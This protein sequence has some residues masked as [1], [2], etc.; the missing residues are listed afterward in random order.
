MKTTILLLALVGS[1]AAQDKTLNCNSNRS[2]SNDRASFCEMR[3]STVPA[4][5]RLDVDPGTNGGI[6]IKGWDRAE[7]LVRQQVQTWEDSDGAAKA[8]AGQ[9]RVNTSAG[10]IRVDGPSTGGRHQGWS[11]SFEV[12]VPRQTDLILKAHNGGIGIS[13]VRGNIQFDAQNGGVHLTNLAGSV[14]GHTQNGG[15]HVELAGTRWDGEKLDVTTTNGGV[16]VTM[17][18]GY[19][20]HLETGTV[21]GGIHIDFPITVHGQISKQFST[22][23]NGGG[24]LVRVMTTNGGVHIG[25]S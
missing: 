25:K 21:N 19:A 9:V 23:I 13:G 14:H 10:Q 20:A 16:H 4:T 5:G 15:L 22:D 6:N 3:E 8:L 7:V 2:W 12:F 17:P 1:L 24:P 18:E 11:V